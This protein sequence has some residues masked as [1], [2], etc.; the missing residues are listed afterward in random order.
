MGEVQIGGEDTAHMVWEL[1]NVNGKDLIRTEIQF[2]AFMMCK[3]KSEKNAVIVIVV[4][5]AL[6]YFS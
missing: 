2:Q 3:K 4:V 5:V 6:F 1:P